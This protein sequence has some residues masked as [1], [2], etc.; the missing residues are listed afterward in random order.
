M[1]Y[2]QKIFHE[3]TQSFVDDGIRK[4]AK[5]EKWGNQRKISFAAPCQ[6]THI[7][8]QPHI[9]RKNPAQ[10][11][12]ILAQN[13]EKE[14]NWNSTTKTQQQR[15]NNSKSVSVLIADLILETWWW[16]AERWSTLAKQRPKTV[17]SRFAIGSMER[18]KNISHLSPIRCRSSHIQRDFRSKIFTPE[19]LVSSMRSAIMYRQWLA[20]PFRQFNGSDAAR[21]EGDD[22]L[23]DWPGEYRGVWIIFAADI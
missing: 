16:I 19:S 4:Y 5:Q 17:K 3:I 20:F 14:T 9:W 13:E 7:Q 15:K 22:T 11:F 10:S 8:P 6:V 18:I 2:S 21:C 12:F 23:T 1:C